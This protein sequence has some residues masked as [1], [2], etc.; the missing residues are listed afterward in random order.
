MVD[1]RPPCRRAQ[2]AARGS[3]RGWWDPLA[4][5]APD[6]TAPWTHEHDFGRSRHGHRR[7][8]RR[9]LVR[10]TLADRVVAPFEAAAGHAIVAAAL[11]QGASVAAA[12]AGSVVVGLAVAGPDDA[13]LALGVAPDPSHATGLAT[14]LL[15]ASLGPDRRGHRRPNGIP[16]IRSRT[17]L[18]AEVARRTL[19]A[20]G[21]AVSAAPAD[22][23]SVDPLALAATRD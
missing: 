19:E 14:A 17:R 13:L 12:V 22:V 23:R 3:A 5:E 15:R 6:R 20:A 18:R 4:S 10:L 2:A 7:R 1:A 21:F 9:R 8:A 11:A 16:S